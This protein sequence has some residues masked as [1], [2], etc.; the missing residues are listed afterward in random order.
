MANETKNKSVALANATAHK[1]VISEAILFAEHCGN[2]QLIPV[3]YRGKAA[4]IVSAVVWGRSLG[5]DPFQ[6]LAGIAVING[7]SCVW[8]D[9]LAAL[10]RRHS[11]CKGIS[12][13]FNET[14]MTATCVVK[15]NDETITQSF[16]KKDAEQAGLWSKVGPWRTYPKRMLQMRARSWAIRDAFPDALQGIYVAEEAMDITDVQNDAA[17]TSITIE[18]VEA[19]IVPTTAK[20][21]TSN[22]AAPTTQTPISAVKPANNPTSTP[23]IVSSSD[24]K[25]TIGEALKQIGL[26]PEFNGNFVAARGKTYGKSEMLKSLGFAYKADTKVWY[27]K[28]A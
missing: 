13:S 12:E 9:T 2:S 8:G 23:V 19:E 26:S 28:V 11:E 15:R 7:K 14:T 24:G 25:E 16:S 5:L 4:D 1:S 21:E 10:A 3:A 20:G 27:R 6:S 17:P 22:D 18:A